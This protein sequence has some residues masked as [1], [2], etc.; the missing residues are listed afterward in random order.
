VIAS[1]LGATMEV[2]RMQVAQ[3]IQY[4]GVHGQGATPGLALTKESSRLVE[5]LALMD[6]HREA[7][8]RIPEESRVAALLREA[9][10]EGSLHTPAEAGVPDQTAGDPALAEQEMPSAPRET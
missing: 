1:N 2:N 3:A 8:A 5:V 7:A 6:F 9:L 10:P 4:W